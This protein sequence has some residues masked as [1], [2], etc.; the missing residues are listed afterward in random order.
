MTT[1]VDV[2]GELAKNLGTGLVVRYR[3]YGNPLGIA[4]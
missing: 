2:F 3:D 1:A 4:E